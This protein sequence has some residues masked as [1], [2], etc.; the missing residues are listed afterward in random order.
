MC[1]R[2][3]AQ[4]ALADRC[5]RRSSRSRA[6]DV[7]ARSRAAAA[8][9]AS[10]VILGSSPG[11]GDRVTVHVLWIPAREVE[12]V[13]FTGTRAT[14]THRLHCRRLPFHRQTKDVTSSI[15]ISV[16]FDEGEGHPG[17]VGGRRVQKDGNGSGSGQWQRSVARQLIPKPRHLKP[18]GHRM[19]FLLSRLTVKPGLQTAAR[20]RCSGCATEAVLLSRHGAHA[21]ALRFYTGACAV[22]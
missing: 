7:S 4:Q 16:P 12:L 15:F 9:D 2:P 13:Y 5:S 18:S 1:V 21:V 11:W 20:R 19:C 14:A 6:A 22:G 17:H 8:G 3:S 10:P